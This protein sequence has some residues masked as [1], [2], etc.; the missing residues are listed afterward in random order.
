M[1]TFYA[2]KYS[3]ADITLQSGRLF[4]LWRLLCES[5]YFC[6]LNKP[7]CHLNKTH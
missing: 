7:V 1:H 4:M 3:T 5:V 6:D 2:G